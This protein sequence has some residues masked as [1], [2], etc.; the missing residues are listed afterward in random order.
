MEIFFLFCFG[1]ILF[2]LLI[3]LAQSVKVVQQYE[4]GVILRLG[5]FA[6]LAE[7][8]IIFLIPF[9][10]K[11]IMTDMRE[12]VI[13]VP[14]QDV[15]TEDNATV[16]VDAVVYYKVVDPV[17]ATFEV[18]NFDLACTTL[19]QTNLRNVI[20]DLSLDESLTSR[21]KINVNLRDVLDEATN[22]WGVKITRVEVKR[23]DPPTDI[24]EAMSRQMKA[25]RDKRAAILEAEGV[26]QS[27]ILQAEG[28][29]ESQVLEAQGA[30]EAEIA[31]AE[32]EAK[33]IQVVAEAA[34]EHFL[35]RAET[36]KRLEVARD[37]LQYN[38][39]FVIPEGSDLIN[40]LGDIDSAAGI[41]PVTK[42][43]K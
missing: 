12:R 31:R 11:M 20:G 14:P 39:K 27:R 24:S 40:I 22:P 28:L 7:P 13:N 17:N 8:G 30:A 33:A 41:V 19:A 37:A 35:S 4:K 36:F 29:K 38:T 3:A 16:Q 21:D 1:F 9:L 6:G 15:I 32:A 25:E 5:K 23:I 2:I 26:K 10:D 18:E 42:D 34:E 43:K